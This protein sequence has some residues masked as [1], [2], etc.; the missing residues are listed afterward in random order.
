MT[1]ISARGAHPLQT[2]DTGT[3][4]AGNVEIENGLARNATGR[5]RLDAFQVQVSYG[6]TPTLDLLLQP[7][8]IWQRLA[9][10]T[11][12]RGA[13]DTNLDAKWRFFGEAPASLALRAGLTLPT[14][15][16]GLGIH[17]GNVSPHA[18]LVLTLDA[19]PWTAHANLGYTHVPG[20][21]GVR[22][23][24]GHA[25]AAAMLALSDSLTVA[26]EAAIDSDS[27][28][29][30]S[31]WPGNVLIGVIYTLVPGLDLDVGRQ[32]SVDAR[33]SNRAWLM[34]VTYRFAP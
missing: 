23:D 20:G 17:R 25:S 13:G 34:G 18:L 3:Q 22:R 5:D 14:S 2:E 9:D 24:L 31:G 16:P 29:R 21:E 28:K 11:A 7:S 4:G 32:V 12:L 26:A 33:K 19:A 27:D 1:T 10:G 30:R 6:L 15:E 8:W